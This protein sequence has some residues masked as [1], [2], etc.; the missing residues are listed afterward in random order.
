MLFHR[1]PSTL[2]R[3]VSLS[4]HKTP[5]TQR[6]KSEFRNSNL[7]IFLG[8]LCP[9]TQG[10]EFVEPRL[11]ASHSDLVAALPRWVS[12]VN[13]PSQET[14]KR[15]KKCAPSGLSKKF[16]EEFVFLRKKKRP[17][18]SSCNFAF[19]WSSVSARSGIR[20]FCCRIEG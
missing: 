15:R 7:E 18:R 16:G 10:G 8:A 19:C 12:A 11:C 2:L 14:E 20:Y 4:N 3:V 1:A 5:R 17:A 6:V 9:S 13:T